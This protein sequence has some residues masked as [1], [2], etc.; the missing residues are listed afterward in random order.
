MSGLPP[1]EARTRSPDVLRHVGLGEERYRPTGDYSTGMK[2]RAKFARAFV[3]DP[4][5]VLLDEPTSGLDPTGRQEMLELILRT[6]RDFGTSILLSSHLV[7]DVER[8]R[9]VVHLV[10]LASAARGY[11]ADVRVAVRNRPQDEVAGRDLPATQPLIRTCVRGS[12]RKQ[13]ASVKS[14]RHSL[15][16]SRTEAQAVMMPG[17]RAAFPVPPY[18]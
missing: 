7:G 1:H 4:L 5:I 17:Q 16:A 9:I 14:S 12:R 15:A 10:P 18:R 3:H 11:L 13:L 6:G 2:Q 8:P